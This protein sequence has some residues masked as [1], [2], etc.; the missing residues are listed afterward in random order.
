MI[1]LGRKNLKE[2]WDTVHTLR[3]FSRVSKADFKGGLPIV[4]VHGLGVSSRYMVPLA[5]EW[6]AAHPVY[7]PDLPGYGRSQKPQD[8]PDVRELASLLRE[9]LRVVGIERAAFVGN[10]MGCQVIVELAHIDASCIVAVA[11]L[12]PTM[13]QTVASRLSHVAGLLKDQFREPPMLVP[14]QAFDYL[15]NGP[16]RTIRTFIH[17]TRHDMLKRA[18]QLRVP[19]L[20]LRGEHDEIVSQKWVEKLAKGIPRAV[21]RELPGAGHAL[22]YNSAETVAPLIEGFWQEC[23]ILP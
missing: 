19:C 14:L 9:W 16:I 8:V 22:N 11:M 2:R 13:D 20:I 23:G 3:V 17:A 12:G 5:T 15:H 6:A 10:S 21:L 4:L 1:L 18:R 7:V